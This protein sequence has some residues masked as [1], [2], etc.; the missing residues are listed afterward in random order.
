[1]HRKRTPTFHIPAADDALPFKVVAM[2]L[3][4]Q[5]PK[6]QGYDAILTIVDQGCSRAAIFLP[7]HTTITG[8]EVAQLY[9]E[10]VYQWFGLPAKVISDQDP[11][12]MSHFAKALCT[13]LQIKQ[14]VS[15]AFHPQ[16]DGLSE[17]KNQWVEQYLRLVT[18]A[19]QDDWKRW[20]PLTTLVH[21]NQ[22]NGT[23]KMALNQALLGY[24]PT[25]NPEAPTNMM[26]EH[27][28]DQIALAHEYRSK[29]QTALNA[30]A[31]TPENQF[32][33]NDHVWLKVKN[34]NLPYQT[35][36]LA[37]K[38][39][40]LFTIMQRV[41]PVAYCLQLPPTWTIHDVFH[42]LLLMRYHE[43]QEHGVNYTRPPP[44]IVNGDQEFKVERIMGH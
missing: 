44:Q 28:E 3:I 5:L 21:N 37:P 31:N 14:N 33:V 36:K 1:M 29:A 32:K 43:T 17:R 26:N 13:K 2:D 20:L 34:L 6:S 22:Y 9:A 40:G 27:V 11:H 12:F 23:I 7:C 24:L 41:S 8:E 18:S 35:Q 19:Q 42:A 38:Q 4:T 39:H 16:M 10:N 30:K 25:L 15:T